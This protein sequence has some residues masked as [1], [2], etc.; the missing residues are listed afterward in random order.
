MSPIPQGAKIPKI[1]GGIAILKAS[2]DTGF[3][4]STFPATCPWSFEQIMDEEFWP[5]G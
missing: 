3:L 2:A 1:Q 5:E 4:E